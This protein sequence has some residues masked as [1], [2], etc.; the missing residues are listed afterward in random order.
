VHLALQLV[1]GLSMLFLLT[2]AAGAAQWAAKL[3]HKRRAE[4]DALRAGVAVPGAAATPIVGV[5]PAAGPD[6]V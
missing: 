5:L 1:P 4:L 2:T 3:E 6:A